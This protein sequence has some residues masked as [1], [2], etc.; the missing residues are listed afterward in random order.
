MDGSV[1]SKFDTIMCGP[2]QPDQHKSKKQRSN[3]DDDIEQ[4]RD[5]LIV[6][7]AK[8]TCKL[9]EQVR[10]HDYLLLRCFLVDKSSKWSTEGKACLQQYSKLTKGKKGH[11]QGR[12]EQCLAMAFLKSR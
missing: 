5:Q 11:A 8:L 6:I 12:P 1:L 9:D 10:V 7:L 2:E 4:W 3:D